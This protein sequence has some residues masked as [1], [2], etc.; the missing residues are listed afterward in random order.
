MAPTASEEPSFEAAR[1]ACKLCSPLGAALVFRGVRGGMPFLHGSQGCATYIR[2]YLISHYREPVDIASSNFSEETAVFGGAVILEK[3]LENVRRLYKPE[4]IGVATTCLSETIG[5]DVPGLLKTYIGKHS[6]EKDFPALVHAS[7]PSY[8]GTHMDG[9]HAAVMA[10]VSALA[11]GGPRGNRIAV[12]PGM[13]SAADL[14]RLRGIFSD[15][16]LSPILTPDYGDSLDGPV[17]EEY[18]PIADGGTPVEDLRA[19]GQTAASIQFGRILAGQAGPGDLLLERFQ[20]PRY[21][22]GLPIGLRETDW[23]Y[24]TLAALSG[25]AIPADRQRERGRLLDALVDGHKYLQGRRA[26]L[27]GEEDLVV[28]LASFLMETG[29]RP[30][31]CASGSRSGRLAEALRAVTPPD[32]EP[33]EACEGADFAELE[34]AA[35]EWKP[36]L[37]LGNSKGYRMARRLG[38]PLIRVG[39]PVHDRFGAARLRHLGYDGA[40]ELYDRLVNAVMERAQDTNPTGYSYL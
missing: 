1:N 39:F 14:R 7:T 17:W 21:K 29:V 15:F 34:K 6:R 12:F 10:L 16:G 30:V 37:L 31:L 5:E 8:R 11:Q 4:L 32:Q 19:L 3:G 36:D 13:V 25:R 9:F 2:R 38:I 23:L 18:R 20:V 28:G 22:L 24:D 33:P 35:A 40:L 26:I 27:Y